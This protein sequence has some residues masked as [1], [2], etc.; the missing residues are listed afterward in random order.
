LPHLTAL[1]RLSLDLRRE[2]PMPQIRC[3]ELDLLTDELNEAYLRLK[4]A[5]S[6]KDATNAANELARVVRCF[7]VH[8]VGCVLCKVQSSA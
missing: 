1:P 3:P 8:R 5:A 7:S 6:T 4:E 2:V